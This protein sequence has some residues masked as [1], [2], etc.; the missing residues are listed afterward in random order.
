MTVSLTDEQWGAV[1]RCLAKIGCGRMK[2][3]NGNY[4]RLS[5]EKMQQIA[6]ET[7]DFINQRYDQK[8]VDDT[9]EPMP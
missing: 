4:Q 9:C 1:F 8:F 7:A 6:R 2:N 5:R 3:R